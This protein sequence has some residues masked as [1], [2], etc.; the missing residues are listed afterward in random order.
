MDIHFYDL[1]SAVADFDFLLGLWER[2]FG[3]NLKHP[4]WD[5]AADDARLLRLNHRWSRWAHY[6]NYNQNDKNHKIEEIIKVRVNPQ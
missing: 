4:N 1:R 3:R 5:C 6:L 2:E